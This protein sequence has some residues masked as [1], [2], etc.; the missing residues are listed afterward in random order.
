MPIARQ[1]AE[2]ALALVPNKYENLSVEELNQHKSFLVAE[3]VRLFRESLK[4]NSQPLD[5]EE[6]TSAAAK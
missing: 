6:P 4:E 1:M 3:A 5:D 2:K